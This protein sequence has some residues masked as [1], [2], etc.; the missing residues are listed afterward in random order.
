MRSAAALPLDDVLEAD[1]QRMVVQ[2]AKQLGYRVY[3][4]FNSRRSTHGFPDLCLVGRR[5]IFLELK[6]ETG[7]LTVEQ[8]DW[9][10]AMVQTGAEVYVV[11]PRDLEELAAVLSSI[12]PGSVRLEAATREELTT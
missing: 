7:K 12:A 5:L 2:L 1:W 3:H 10:A 8:R 4:T 9:L 6:R 11:R